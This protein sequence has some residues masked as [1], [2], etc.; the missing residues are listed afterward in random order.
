[1]SG[2]AEA[3]ARIA[4]H[5]A[6]ARAV[7][8]VGEVTEAHSGTTDHAV[9]VRLR[10]TDLLLPRVPVA[11]GVLGYAAIPAVGDLVLVVF[12]EGDRNAPVVV[13]RLYHPDVNPP[14]HADGQIVL[15]LPAGA[16]EPD[17]RVLVEPG[18]KK[19]SIEIGGETRA[20]ITDTEVRLQVADDLAAKLETAGGGRIEL[21]A[22]GSTLTLKKNGDVTLKAAGKLE[23]SGTEV[24]V[25]GTA[26]V[27]VKGALVELN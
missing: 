8:A 17:V 5:E 7:A 18:A 19:V 25:N 1:M 12:G 10:D 4:R 26:K 20:E 23:L 22:G 9:T 13:G 3:V 11:V 21:S 6:A 2:L 24:A 14:D 16:D 15:A 27:A